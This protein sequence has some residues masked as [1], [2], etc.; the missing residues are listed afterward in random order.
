MNRL[1]VHRRV[2]CAMVALAAAQAHADGLSVV[3]GSPRAIGRAGAA[4]VGDDGGGALLVNPA[5]M[6]RRDTARGQ[7]G[8][9][10]VDDALVW[11]SDAGAAP[12]SKGEAPTQLA[13][14]GAVIG[15]IGDWILGAGIMTS[16]VT[17]RAMPQPTD[18]N[19]GFFGSYFD[20]R[21]AGISGSYRRDTLSV[22]VA[23]RIGDSLA[24]GLALGASQVRA[25]E[26]R[27]IWAG[28]GGRD[29]ISA[30]SW[31][32]DLTFHASDRFAASAVA[33]V[34][35]APGDTKV[36]LGASVAWADTVNL[37]GTPSG[38]T[39]GGPGP[40]VKYPYAP[41][42]TLQV[43]QPL[44]VR[45][46]ARYVGDRFV[47]EVDG[48]LWLLPASA[49]SATWWVHGVRLKDSSDFTVD[50]QR[51]PSRISQCTHAAVHGA[52]DVELIPGFL[53]ATGGYAYAG[54]GTPSERLSPTFADLGGHTLGLGLETTAGGFTV[55]F[56]WS[57]TWSLSA[58]V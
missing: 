28:F 16:G 24:F 1:A 18:P 54:R 17:D 58:N 51:V 33:G 43:R 31:D 22:G 23:R 9:A 47:A 35:Y 5:A 3:G 36:E 19:S 46:G 56:G 38:E 29:A 32:V 34:L 15:A 57:R 27:R 55:T 21:Y 26:Q 48:D 8:L 49:E 44:A 7:V 13:P 39:T 20:Y 25:T 2:I 10:L 40:M 42:A 37:E 45:G 6:A 4:T 14:L 41:R 50:L 12:L 30:P 11:Q 53:W 52:V